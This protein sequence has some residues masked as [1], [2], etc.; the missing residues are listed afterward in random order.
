MGLRFC[1][2]KSVSGRACWLSGVGFGAAGQ[3]ELIC[4]GLKVNTGEA[5]Q[6]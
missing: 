5:P 4:A 3:T 1:G 2:A 6:T